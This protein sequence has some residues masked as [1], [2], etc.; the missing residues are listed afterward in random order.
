M[1]VA[2]CFIVAPLTVFV[3]SVKK[4]KRQKEAI[5]FI[6]KLFWLPIAQVG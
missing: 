1:S 6:R 2:Y 3:R 4:K 5:S